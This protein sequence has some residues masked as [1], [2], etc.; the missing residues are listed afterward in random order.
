AVAVKVTRG[1]AHSCLCITLFVKGHSGSESDV[2]KGAISIVA[3]KDARFGI[4]RDINIG[5]A[6]VVEVEWGDG[7]RIAIADSRDLR[8]FGNVLK[9]ASTLIVEELVGTTRQSTRPT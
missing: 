3:E 6:I 5:P 2:S 8:G 1:R 7:E 9:V 4:N